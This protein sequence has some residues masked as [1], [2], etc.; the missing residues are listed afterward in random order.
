MQTTIK[1]MSA[2]VLSLV[3]GLNIAAAQTSVVCTDSDNGKNLSLPGKLTLQFFKD[4]TLSK[5]KN[6][7][8]FFSGTRNRYLEFYCNG[9]Q[10]SYEIVTCPNEELGKACPV[11]E[12][13]TAEPKI[14]VR[15]GD[16]IFPEVLIPGMRDF[17]I[18]NFSLKAY[19]GEAYL[20]GLH[21]TLNDPGTVS[22]GVLTLNEIETA[23][24]YAFE[25]YDRLDNLISQTKST[26]GRVHFEFDDTA[27]LLSGEED[28]TV[29]IN[30]S[31]VENLT[32]SWRWF[33]LSLD[34]S[35]AGNG[36]QARSAG[37]GN[38]VDGV[39]L[40]Q[41]GAWPSSALY[42]N[43]A[44]K[45]KLDHANKQPV[46]VSP[47][48]KGQEFYHFTVSADKAGPAQIE[49]L[50]IEALL[51]G[52]KFSENPAARVFLVKSDGTLDFTKA[53]EDVTTVT[54]T[55]TANQEA[56]IEIDFKEQLILAGQTNTYAL[57]LNRTEEI[58]S[59]TDNSYVFTLQGDDKKSTTRDGDLLKTASNLV[60]SDFPGI[61]NKNRFMRGFLMDVRTVA[62]AFLD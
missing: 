33:R 43:A 32:D 20:R 8:D 52:F 59:E 47:A 3:L 56:L 62:K 53:I 58:G 38:F 6:Y 2:A 11:I 16:P 55:G 31:L 34:K 19:D 54:L 42:I 48:L 35:Y 39:V 44:T 57:F 26:A 7:Q 12:S 60:W 45:I 50:T 46:K 41:I 22:A 30:L 13:L 23:G 28:F 1:I 29:K 10:P 49:K 24:L 18:L 40:G 5:T 36:V 14:E 4:R 61:L 9:N 27:Y 17:P 15:N 51:E 25:L 37:S 21:F